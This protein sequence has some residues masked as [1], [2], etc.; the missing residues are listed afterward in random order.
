PVNVRVRKRYLD[1]TQRKRMEKAK[2]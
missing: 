1:P 2:S